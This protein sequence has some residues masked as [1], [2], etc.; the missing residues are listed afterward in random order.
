MLT[1]QDVRPFTLRST[2]GFH[3]DAQGPN[4]R[5]PLSSGSNG[6]TSL[7]HSTPEAELA[8]ADF[9][10]KTKGE[11]ALCLW[12]KLLERYHGNKRC[13]G[14]SFNKQKRCEP[15]NRN[16]AR[17][18]WKLRINN[19]EDNTTALTVAATGKNPTMKTLERCHGV[20]VAS[21]HQGVLDGVYNWIHTRSEH[22]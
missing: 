12:Q 1:L 18:P 4:S 17:E 13:N 15:E 21:I 11:P 22:T 2:S 14:R 7:A 5:F 19:H 9:A 20:S 16:Q 8:S 3:L 10:I 6:Q